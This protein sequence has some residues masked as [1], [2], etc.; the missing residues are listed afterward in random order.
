MI[1]EP[2]RGLQ[3]RPLPLRGRLRASEPVTKIIIT[4]ISNIIRI[5]NTSNT[6]IVT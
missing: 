1:I 6:I 4:I 3:H 5:L 2:G